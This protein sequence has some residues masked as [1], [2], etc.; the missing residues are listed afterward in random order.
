MLT[1]LTGKW[2]RCHHP[3][4]SESY[5]MVPFPGYWGL[6]KTV[7]TIKRK[8]HNPTDLRFWQAVPLPTPICPQLPCVY[9]VDFDAGYLTVTGLHQPRYGAI[10][11]SLG[12]ISADAIRHALQRPLKSASDCTI[13]YSDSS[14]RPLPARLF[15]LGPGAPSQINELQEQFFRDFA[16]HWSDYFLDPI[17][18]NYSS[19]VFHAFSIAVLRLGAWD[20]EVINGCPRR[21]THSI[22]SPVPSWK[23]PKEDIYWFHEHLIVLQEDVASETRK[24]KAIVRAKSYLDT[25]HSG[26][27]AVRVIIM[28]MRHIAFLNVCGDK[29]S[30]SRTIDLL[31]KHFGTVCSPGFRALAQ[32]L[33]S[34]YG[35]HTRVKESWKPSI[36]HEILDMI[37]HELPFR[38]TIAF[39]KASLAMER[40]YYHKGLLSQFDIKV[41]SFD[42]SISCCG[43]RF[44]SSTIR[45]SKCLAWRHLREE[46]GA[47]ADA[48]PDDN[49][50]CGECEEGPKASIL[51]LHALRDDGRRKTSRCKV[52]ANGSEKVFQLVSKSLTDVHQP[53]WTIVFSGHWSGLA[54]GLGDL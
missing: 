11:I 39:A 26:Q 19:G 14:D 1:L 9:A 15:N 2:Y 22:L 40:S 29:V 42:S 46:C 25:Y 8:R 36:P 53:G 41:Q 44:D 20:F 50:I 12:S 51:E 10:R 28:S 31:T 45:C 30:S 54:Y 33:T 32:V 52:Q 5:Q 18:C 47:R 34:P 6:V 35:A 27:Q 23:Y 43:T 4:S 16:F 49:Y 38:D 48:V 13:P 37:L 3:Q 21:R 7:E 24:D 17:T